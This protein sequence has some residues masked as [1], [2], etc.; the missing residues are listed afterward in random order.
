VNRW[1][2]RIGIPVK[3]GEANGV[4]DLGAIRRYVGGR[5][6]KKRSACPEPIDSGR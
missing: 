1:R 4:E 3:M 2:D 5:H 6:G